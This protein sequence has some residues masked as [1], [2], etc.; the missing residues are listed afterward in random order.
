MELV[1][2]MRYILDHNFYKS[3]KMEREKKI[4]LI[5]FRS[6]FF[7]NIEDEGI[8]LVA[9]LNKLFIIFFV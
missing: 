7:V 6:I 2:Y 9:C 5:I 4:N 3:K 8:Q 1:T